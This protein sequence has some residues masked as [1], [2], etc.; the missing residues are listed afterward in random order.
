MSMIYRVYIEKKEGFDAETANLLKDIIEFLEIKN[1]KNLRILYRYDVQG[2]N[3][4]EYQLAKETIFSDPPQD[5]VFD[6]E[7]PFE[8]NDIIFG[9][10]FLPGQYDQLYP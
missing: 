4:K 7:F 6:E 2:I 9:V 8:S 10:E 3:E 5:M 1:L